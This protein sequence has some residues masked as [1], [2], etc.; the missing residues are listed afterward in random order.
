MEFKT[1]KLADTQL[2]FSSSGKPTFT[3]Y[4]SVFG[5]KDSA[6]DIVHKGAFSD[7]LA[8]QGG[9]VK[10]H[11]NHDW[12]Y[13]NLP[14]GKMEVFEDDVGLFVKSAEFT[15]GIKLAGEVASALRHGTVDGLSV[16]IKASADGVQVRNDGIDWLKIAQLREISIVND[17]ANP[18]ARVASV[19]AALAEVETLKDIEA[20]LREAGFSRADACGLVSRVKS[21]AHGERDAERKQKE[22]LL[23][24]ARKALLLQT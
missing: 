14:I 8:R 20:I 3:G 10:M 2:K 12:L 23:A 13:G 5:V 22:E 11:Y 17:P 6:G 15:E 19:K 24:F 4:A 21:L 1:I 16:A 7:A 18:D 9:T